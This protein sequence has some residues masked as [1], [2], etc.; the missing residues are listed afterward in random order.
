MIN[1]GR[2]Y[3]GVATAVAGRD[4]AG[5]WYEILLEVQDPEELATSS[6]TRTVS[7]T[8]WQ[9][10]MNLQLQRM[11]SQRHSWRWLQEYRQCYQTMIFSNAEELK[12]RNGLQEWPGCLDILTY[13]GV[14]SASR[15][16][17][18]VLEG[19]G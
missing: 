13:C 6:S 1:G 4:A 3:V 16:H 5:S 8:G 2:L 18:L 10:K 15:N 12:Q 9:G 19:G 11:S 17:T 14:Q 7:A